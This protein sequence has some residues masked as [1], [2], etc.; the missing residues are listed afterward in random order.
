MKKPKLDR[1]EWEFSECLDEDRIA[2]VSY[3]YARQFLREAPD[4]MVALMGN[5]RMRY[6]VQLLSRQHSKKSHVSD[7]FPIFSNHFPHTPWLRLPRDE[8]KRMVELRESLL[9]SDSESELLAPQTWELRNLK[10][11]AKMRQRQFKV[12][13]A[14]AVR[15]MRSDGYMNGKKVSSKVILESCPVAALTPPHFYKYYGHINYALIKLDWRKNDGELIAAFSQLLDRHRASFPGEAKPAKLGPKDSRRSFHVRG[16]RGGPADQLRQLG[17]LRLV[18]YY[19]NCQDAADFMSAQGTDRP[20][21]NAK[22]IETAAR[23]ARSVLG[24][25]KETGRFQ[26]FLPIT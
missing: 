22:N 26:A 2:C 14:E 23:K 1:Y 6:M 10:N 24:N 17:A 8:R 25:M 4:L 5:G 21:K 15:W 20:Y 9:E 16:G 11:F 12:W 18:R 13:K 3:E 7:G 19:E